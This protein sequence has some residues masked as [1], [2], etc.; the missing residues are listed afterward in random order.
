MPAERRRTAAS[1][2]RSPLAIAFG[3]LT[4]LA[5]VACAPAA[6]DVPSVATFDVEGQTFKVELDTQEL[7]D[8]ARQLLDGEEVAGIPVGDIVRDDPSINEPWSWLIDPSSVEFA[9]FTTEVCDGLPEY[10]EDGTLTSDI[11]CPWGAKIT[12]LE[13][14]G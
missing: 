12:A 9:D 7:V 14:M 13:P 11:Y 5:L 4:A 6:P 3:G 1:R 10:V 8:H 2:L